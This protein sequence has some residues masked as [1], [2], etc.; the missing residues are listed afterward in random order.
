VTHCA[1]IGS[2]TFAP[3][4]CP[5]ADA[6]LRCWR[7]AIV[8]GAAQAFRNRSEG[9]AGCRRWTLASA[10]AWQVALAGSRCHPPLPARDGNAQPSSIWPDRANLT[11]PDNNPCARARCPLRATHYLHCYTT[12]ELPF[13]LGELKA[14]TKLDLEG[15][16]R[17]EGASGV[18]QPPSLR[19]ASQPPLSLP[20]SAVATLPSIAGCTRTLTRAVMLPARAGAGGGL[21]AVHTLHTPRSLQDCQS[22]S[23]ISKPFATCAWSAA[24]HYRVS[25]AFGAR[26]RLHERTPG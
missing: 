5:C 14:L 10:P 7:G 18:S 16:V 21:C 23:E 8:H 22:P 6:G 4:R 20:A 13:S 24:R 2:T 15:C 9:F 17:L 26:L 19:S 25:M 3:H 12:A 1:S 11:A